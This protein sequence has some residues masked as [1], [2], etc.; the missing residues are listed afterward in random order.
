MHSNECTMSAVMIKN[1]INAGRILCAQRGVHCL[2]ER[3]ALA[4]PNGVGTGALACSSFDPLAFARSLLCLIAS[5]LGLVVAAYCG[6][7]GVGP[8]VVLFGDGVV[9][10]C[11]RG[12]GAGVGGFVV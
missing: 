1:F 9:L 3:R 5:A 10:V 12:A 11:W 8:F 2:I 4:A 7:G 6:A